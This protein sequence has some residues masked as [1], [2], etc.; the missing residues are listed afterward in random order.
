MSL[1]NIKTSLVNNSSRSTVATEVRKLFNE[2]AQRQTKAVGVVYTATIEN[3]AVST[4]ILTD[5]QKIS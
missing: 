1:L 3:L 4:N 2:A 5:L